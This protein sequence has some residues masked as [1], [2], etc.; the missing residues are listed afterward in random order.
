MAET[1]LPA[2]QAEDNQVPFETAEEAQDV[3]LDNGEAQETTEAAPVEAS[4]E[5]EVA[6]TDEHGE[7]SDKVQ[8]RINQLTKRIKDT[9]RERDEATRYAQAVQSES[10]QIKGRL[11]TLDESYLSEYGGRVSAEQKQVQDELKRATDVGDTEA[12]VAAQQKIAQLA[13]AADRYHQAK[14]TK[15]RQSEQAEAAPPPV[16]QQQPMPQAAPVAP[17]APDP[18]AEEWAERNKWFGAEN[19]E[20]RTFAAFGIHKRLVETE[21]FDPQTD[22]YYDELD[23]RIRNAFPQKFEEVKST[24]SNRPAQTVAGVSRSASTGRR[25][26]RLTPSQVTIAKKL[27]VPLEEYAKYVKE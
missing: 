17:E 15:K 25:K 20:E 24:Q 9:E 3:V 26:V 1:D 10:N 19:E 2:H 8:R 21:G 23:K 5:P 6:A 4:S 27:G 12:M 18:K 16:Q 11:Q 7:Y 14:A 13:V 22:D